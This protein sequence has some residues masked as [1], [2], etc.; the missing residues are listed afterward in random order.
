MSLEH[1]RNVVLD[2]NLASVSEVAKDLV[3]EGRLSTTKMNSE[4][5]VVDGES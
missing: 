3:N 1:L 2:H 5:P 4:P